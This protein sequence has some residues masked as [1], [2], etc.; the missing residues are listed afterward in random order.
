MTTVKEACEARWETWKADCSGFLKA[1]AADVGIEL[2]GQAN[3]IID[4]VGTAPWVQ[5]ESDADCAVSYAGMGYLVVA[6]L[7]ANPNGHVCVIVSGASK[8]YPSA[9]WGRLNAVGKKNATINWAWT[10]ADLAKIQYYAM[11]PKS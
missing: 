2:T 9:Y 10:H 4:T 7:K 8:P 5:L 6:G 1:V 3:A 11:M